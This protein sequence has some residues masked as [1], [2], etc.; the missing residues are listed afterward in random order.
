MELQR[1]TTVRDVCANNCVQDL[2][3]LIQITPHL[4][5]WNLA[6]D[7]IEQVLNNYHQLFR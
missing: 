3:G 6:A 5:D 7:C 1:W 2:R 4:P